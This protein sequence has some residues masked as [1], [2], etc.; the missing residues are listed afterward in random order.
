MHTPQALPIMQADQD[1][2][3]PGWML[4]PPWSPFWVKL[5]FSL[6]EHYSLNLGYALLQLSGHFSHRGGEMSAEGLKLE[7]MG[8]I[9]HLTDLPLPSP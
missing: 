1:P 4:T 3:A 5:K 7:K 2:H 6:W 9:P 8:L